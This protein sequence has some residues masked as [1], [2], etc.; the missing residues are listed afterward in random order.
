MRIYVIMV[1]FEGRLIG[2]IPV[3]LNIN[4]L[5]AVFVRLGKDLFP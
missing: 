1:F 5:Q 4:D 2:G 3:Y